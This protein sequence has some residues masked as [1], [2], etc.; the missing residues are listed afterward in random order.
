MIKNINIGELSI[1]LV[2]RHRWEPKDKQRF[3]IMFNDYKLGIWFKKA[4]CVGKTNCGNP[5]EWKNNLRP[6]IMIGLDLIVIKCWVDI[7]Y[8]VMHLERKD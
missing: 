7:T 8:G 6:S 1:T 5:K 4:M 2:L 3:T